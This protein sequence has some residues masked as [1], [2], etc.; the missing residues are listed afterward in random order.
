MKHRLYDI[1]MALVGTSET[2]ATGAIL[3][4]Y[5]KRR[6]LV[7]S[8]Y[9]KTSSTFTLPSG[10]APGAQ[11]IGVGL[12]LNSDGRAT[13][14][15]QMVVRATGV[16]DLYYAG[17]YNSASMGLSYLATGDKMSAECEWIVGT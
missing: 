7:L 14:V 8:S 13:A 2:L 6:K 10:D 12:R 9:A 1:L 15:G 16:V 5:G 4:R 3:Y 17:S 11:T